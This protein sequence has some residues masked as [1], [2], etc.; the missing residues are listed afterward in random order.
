[1]VSIGATMSDWNKYYEDINNLQKQRENMRR[2]YDHYDEKM[3]KFIKIRDEK[4]FKNVNETQ[5]EL[6]KFA[7]VLY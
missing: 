5:P 7:R 4:A 3:E 2:I 6:T 1:M